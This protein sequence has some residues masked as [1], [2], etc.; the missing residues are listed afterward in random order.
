MHHQIKSVIVISLLLINT[1][2]AYTEVY[3]W[4]D[5][6][7]RTIYGDK[8]GNDG[9]AIVELKKDK[10]NSADSEQRAQKRQKLLD[11]ID[12]ERKTKIA[13]KEKLKKQKQEQQEKCRLLAA[14]LEDIKN[15]SYLYEETDDPYNPRIASDEER[16]SREME[17]Q[18][19]L[20]DNC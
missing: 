19:Y 13:E 15:A 18:D 3:K 6:N 9:A 16:K 8:P 17:Y 11:V 4:V 10:V 14:E 5:E 12:E 7:G 2:P 1:K 20:N